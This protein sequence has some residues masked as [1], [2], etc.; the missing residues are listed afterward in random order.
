MSTH[1]KHFHDK[2][3][4]IPKIFIIFVSEEFYK[5]LKSKFELA[6][7]KES[8]VFES[9]RSYCIYIKPLLS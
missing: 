1:N 9:L 4:K 6:K 5:G 8:S 7:I 2:I 3:G